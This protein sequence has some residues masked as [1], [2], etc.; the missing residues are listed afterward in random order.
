M[1]REET[2]ENSPTLGLL[3]VLCLWQVPFLGTVFPLP[4][5]SLPNKSLLID[6]KSPKMTRAAHYNSGCNEQNLD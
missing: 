5:P 4:Q 2:A 1:G 3:T 6:N